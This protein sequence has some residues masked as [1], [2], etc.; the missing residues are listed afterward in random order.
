VWLKT[1]LPDR[2]IILSDLSRLEPLAWPQIVPKSR[3]CK[4]RFHEAIQFD[5]SRWFGPRENFTFRKSKIMHIFWPTRLDMWGVRVVT[6]ARRAAM[7]ANALS[8]VRCVSGRP[9]RVVLA[10]LGWR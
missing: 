5:R 7:D 9:S 10:P 6:N 1:D 8:D 4:K 3:A 2:Q